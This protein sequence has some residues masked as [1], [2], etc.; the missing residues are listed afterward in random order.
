M[1]MQTGEGVS[2]DISVIFE[3]I[4]PNVGS[5]CKTMLI[6]PMW[7]ATIN[8]WFGPYCTESGLVLF[9]GNK[10]QQSAFEV[11][12]VQTNFFTLFFPK[13]SDANHPSFEIFSYTLEAW[14][15]KGYSVSNHI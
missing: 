3:G 12:L 2:A 4:I 11:R 13:S 7:S 1:N 15:I 9:C 10:W 8:I 14:L 6:N 5:M